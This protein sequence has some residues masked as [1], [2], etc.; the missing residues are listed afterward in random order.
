MCPVCTILFLFCKK[1][2][3]IFDNKSKWW[4][5]LKKKK[6][7]YIWEI[8][9]HTHTHTYMYTLGH[10]NDLIY[11]YIFLCISVTPGKAKDFFH[12]VYWKNLSHWGFNHCL[13]LLS[14]PNQWLLVNQEFRLNLKGV[15]RGFDKTVNLKRP[16]NKTRRSQRVETSNVEGMRK[17]PQDPAVGFS[18]TPPWWTPAEGT[19]RLDQKYQL[20]GRPEFLLSTSVPPW[21]P[22]WEVRGKEEPS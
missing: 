21:R 6:T 13:K 19:Q 2:W 17:E 9:T 18:L 12:C 16:R 4:K 11:V 8:H 15:Q 5:M 10:L 22:S 1:S 14:P 20:A 3:T 7:K